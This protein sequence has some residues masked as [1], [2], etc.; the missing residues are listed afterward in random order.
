MSQTLNSFTVVQTTTSRPCKLK[1]R[2][3]LSGLAATSNSTQCPS[4]AT[5]AHIAAI[6]VP[7]TVGLV[8]KM[9]LETSW[10][11]ADFRSGTKVEALL[12]HL[13]RAK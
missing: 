10:S 6:N 12:P 5:I 11:L 8:A 2:L 1:T 4:H 9:A 7:Y 3:G 13:L